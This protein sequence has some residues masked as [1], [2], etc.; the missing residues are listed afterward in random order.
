MVGGINESFR[1]VW[2]LVEWYMHSPVDMDL[3]K[4]GRRADASVQRKPGWLEFLYSH[5]PKIG[6]P[7][8]TVRKGD[9][10]TSRER[11]MQEINVDPEYRI[12]IKEFTKWLEDNDLYS[13]FMKMLNDPNEDVYD[14]AQD[15]SIPV[16][17]VKYF[18]RTA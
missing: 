17:M 12:S 14:I 1:K 3:V 9:D 7:K 8:K 18:L 2:D 5:V 11:Y 15:F 13:T 16:S 6:T 10:M 4:L